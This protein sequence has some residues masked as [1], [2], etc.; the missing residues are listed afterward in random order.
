MVKWG[1]SSAW[2]DSSAGLGVVPPWK[3]TD[4]LITR[5]GGPIIAPGHSKT[6]LLNRYN[7]VI[8]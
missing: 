8:L 1:K 7:G 4:T 5:H 2:A 3:G 6:G